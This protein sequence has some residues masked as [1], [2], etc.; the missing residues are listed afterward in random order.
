MPEYKNQHYVPRAHFKPFSLD[1][2]GKAV[3]IYL[4]HKDRVVLGAPIAGQCARSYFY[5]E[6]GR[7]E[8]L[9]GRMEGA[10]GALVRKLADESWTPAKTASF[11]AGRSGEDVVRCCA[12]IMGALLVCFQRHFGQSDP[13]F[14][15]VRQSHPMLSRRSWKI[16]RLKL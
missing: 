14:P 13:V 10:Y 6:D 15:G 1:G 5:G 8:K 2:E 9:L 4:L 3:N 12:T 7:L 11:E 16:S